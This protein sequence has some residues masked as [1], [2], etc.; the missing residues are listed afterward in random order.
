MRIKFKIAT[1]EK[2]IHED[3]IDQLS[4]PT[5]MGEVTILPNHIPLVAT[6]VPGEIRVVDGNGTRTMVVT[7]GF[8]E[9]QPDSRVIVLADSAESDEEV[10]LKRAEE[11]RE[12]AR[13]IMAEDSVD[14]EKYAVAQASLERSMARIR[15]ARK[16]NKYRD[17][18]K[19]R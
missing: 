1:P 16:K 6:I 11:A 13:K 4:C 12:R 14:A 7:G 17:V 5:T 10:D 2:V 18:G 19:T 8:L 9:V 15:F 3:E